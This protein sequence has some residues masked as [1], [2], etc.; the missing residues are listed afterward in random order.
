LGLVSTFDFI[1][2]I[3]DKVVGVNF[4]LMIVIY[5]Q[6]IAYILLHADSVASLTNKHMA[7]DT[8]SDLVNLLHQH[9]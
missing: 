4:L 3:E 8:V 6:L 9:R 2:G 5:M 1:L 7:Q